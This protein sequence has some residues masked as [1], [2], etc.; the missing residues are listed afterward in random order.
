MRS[1]LHLTDHEHVNRNIK[2]QLHR[3]TCI[4]VP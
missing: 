3:K 2:P 1:K 4:E